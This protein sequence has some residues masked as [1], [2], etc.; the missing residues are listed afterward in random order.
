MLHLA[1]GWPGESCNYGYPHSSQLIVSDKFTIGCSL[2][3]YPGVIYLNGMVIV[4]SILPLWKYKSYSEKKTLDIYMQNFPNS[5]CK[6]HSSHN[7]RSNA[8]HQAYKTYY[9]I[10]QSF[11]KRICYTQITHCKVKIPKFF[12]IIAKTC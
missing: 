7:E 4:S 3:S 12:W 11:S 1:Q 8:K 6:M 5:M 9:N 2:F 10:K